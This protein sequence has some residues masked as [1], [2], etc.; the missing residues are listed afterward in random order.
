MRGNTV[1][2]VGPDDRSGNMLPYLSTVHIPTTWQVPLALLE[3]SDALELASPGDTVRVDERLMH[4]L[5]VIQE[6]VSVVDGTGLPRV[7][8]GSAS[9]AVQVMANGVVA[10]FAIYG[11]PPPA[12]T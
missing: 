11:A 2:T 1:Y 9:Y 3:V 12:L 7:D 10:G 8:G 6:G 4:T 5:L